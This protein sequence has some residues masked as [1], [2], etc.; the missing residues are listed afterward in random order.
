MA[1]RFMG[2]NQQQQQGQV[3]TG[4]PMDLAFRLLKGNKD[5]CPKCGTPFMYPSIPM[6]TKCG[7]ASE[8]M[9]MTE[10]DHAH[11]EEVYGRSFR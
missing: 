9:L 4:E 2:R 10:E 6:C 8:D 1:N 11:L 5:K 7:Y 3:Q